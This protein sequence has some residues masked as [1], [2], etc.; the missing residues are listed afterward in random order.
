MKPIPIRLMADVLRKFPNAI[1]DEKTFLSHGNDWPS[2][3]WLPMSC[4]YAIMT[5]GAPMS[6]AQSVMLERGGAVWL[7]T[8][9]AVLAWRRTKTIYKFDATLAEALLSQPLEGDLPDSLLMR[10]PE[11]GMWIEAPGIPG[12]FTWLEYDVNSRG[13]ELRVLI[14]EYRGRDPELHSI[15]VL[16]GGGTLDD[17]A[18]RLLESAMERA[19]TDAKRELVV[20][21]QRAQGNAG[22]Y[23]NAQGI[24]NLILYLCSAEPDIADYKPAARRP[25][26]ALPPPAAKSWDVGIRIGSTIRAHNNAVAL[27][28]H[29]AHERREAG[30]RH[31][32][33]RPH[34]RAAHW[35]RYLVGEGRK[36]ITVKWIAPTLVGAQIDHGELPA[37]VRRVK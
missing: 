10:L 16:L 2:W 35:H 13:A 12:F 1:E 18:K 34:I 23:K 22:I 31:A 17:A 14:V 36:D 6:V 27:A 4:A 28:D 29:E 33:P 24:I 8:L 32:S 26:S 5:E 11:W 15:P 25:A 37:V 20:E 19:P 30:E 7:S 9:S 3:C 21:Q